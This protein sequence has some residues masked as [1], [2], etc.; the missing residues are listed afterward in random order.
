MDYY[1]M[2]LNM[3]TITPLRTKVIPNK[4]FVYLHHDKTMLELF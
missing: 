3:Q 1:K 2:G 4:P